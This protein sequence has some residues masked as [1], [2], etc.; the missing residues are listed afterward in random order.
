MRTEEWLDRIYEWA[1]GANG[2]VDMAEKLIREIPGQRARLKE[3]PLISIIGTFKAGKSSTINALLGEEIAPVDVLPTTAKVTSF[4][5]DAETRVRVHQD[6]EWR[7]STLAEFQSLVHSLNESEA[8]L[9]D[10]AKIRSI[11][12]RHPS[13]VLQDLIIVDTPGFGSGNDTDDE[14]TLS[15]LEH[16]AAFV[17]VVDVEK[18]GLPT[19]D[20]RVLNR[21]AE[22]GRPRYLIFNK[23]D[24]KSSSDRRIIL[25][26]AISQ[27]GERFERI[28]LFSA[29]LRQKRDNG[30]VIPADAVTE[31]DLDWEK[32]V[33]PEL[34]G[35]AE[36][37]QEPFIV[38][39]IQPL[40]DSAIL[41]CQEKSKMMVNLAAETL[42][43]I[44]WLHQT[45]TGITNGY[46]S[47]LCSKF[48][49]GIKA[50]FRRRADDFRKSVK[51]DKGFIWDDYELNKEKLKKLAFRM[52]DEVD[53]LS[54]KLREELDKAFDRMAVEYKRA[55]DILAKMG[56]EL[57]GDIV[58][59]HEAP[60]NLSVAQVLAKAECIGHKIHFLRG[61][62]YSS[63]MT[64]GIFGTEDNARILA[65][66]GLREATK[67]LDDL[68]DDERVLGEIQEYVFGK[69][70]RRIL[71]ET[72]EDGEAR[73]QLEGK[74]LLSCESFVEKETELREKGA[75]LTSLES[76]LRD[77]GSPEVKS[78]K[79]ASK[80]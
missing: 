79:G 76:A 27:Y 3:P 47:I 7:S 30:Q 49:T 80:H 11:E 15:Q 2:Y 70:G 36:R 33:L 12:V 43:R 66:E 23:A 20:L 29:D 31:I 57:D 54:N 48:E 75:H 16:A 19:G 17:W 63:I 51:V 35:E 53:K 39:K 52:M 40:I 6:G 22:D 34:R 10:L 61:S 69:S 58:D 55:E 42:Q 64:F 67:M 65:G 13:E 46:G 74:L 4:R 18:G 1:N 44:E 25:E 72:S 56:A 71:P 68:I 37:L 77:I 24:M 28:F 45:A 78:N 9:K 50:L 21:L 32:T 26:K 8:W 41:E 73:S 5:S 59:V 62:I 60:T 38:K 14:E